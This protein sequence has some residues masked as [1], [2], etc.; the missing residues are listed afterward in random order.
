MAA[1]RSRRAG[2]GGTRW[3]R[4]VACV[5]GALVLAGCSRGDLG[6]RI[7][8]LAVLPADVAPYHQMTERATADYVTQALARTPYRLVGA[9]SAAR[10]LAGPRGQDLY[11]RFRDQA[12]IGP[13]VALT[14]AQ[15]LADTLNVQGL[16]LPSLA[17]SVVGPYEGRVA[18]TIQVYDRYTG[19]RVWRN[20]RERAFVGRLGDPGFLKAVNEMANE[21][22]GTLP[23]PEEDMR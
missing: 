22:I 17:V 3:Q 8:S 19:Q 20:R 7:T 18:L 10:L 12:K 5:L 11:R 6:T 14:V 15:T 21:L 2:F 16:V 9:E 1:T 13:E 4:A 23:V